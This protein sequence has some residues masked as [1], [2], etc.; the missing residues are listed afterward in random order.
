MTYSPFNTSAL[1]QSIISKYIEIK[2]NTIFELMQISGSKTL[3]E[4]REKGYDMKITSE[5]TKTT[6][7]L[8]LS[9][10][11]IITYIIYFDPEEHKIKRDRL[12]NTL[13]EDDIG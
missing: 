12:V 5:G 7:S 11:H 13:E 2:E 10:Q 8:S 4:L 3:G 1:I 9:D 6:I